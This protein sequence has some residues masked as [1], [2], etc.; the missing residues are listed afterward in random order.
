MMAWYDA[1]LAK[2][3]VDTTAHYLPTRYG[4]THVIAAGHERDLPPVVLLHGVNTNAAVWRP[5]L[6]GLAAHTRVYAPDVPGFAGKSSGERLPYRGAALAG[7]LADTLDTLDAA[8]ALVVGAS[9]GGYFALKFAAHYP[10]RAAGVLL[11]NPVGVA[12]YRHIYKLTRVPLAIKLLRLGRRWIARRE[13]ARRMVERGMN[14]A[15]HA[16]EE[17]VELAYLLLRDY[18]RHV[19]PPLLP[20][21]ELRRVAAPVSLLVGEREI[22]TDP[23]AVIRRLRAELPTPPAVQMIPGAGHDLNKELPELINAHILAWAACVKSTVMYV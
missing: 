8:Q 13:V 5:Q 14:P 15:L 7:W 9:A 1:A 3:R 19:P 16:T 4:I 10:E 21:S 6:D 12:P 22:Y 2:L 17:N 18:R 11:L 23:G 20:A